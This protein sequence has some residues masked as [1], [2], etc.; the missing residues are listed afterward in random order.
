MGFSYSAYGLCCDFCEQDKSTRK[1]VKKIEC[2]YGYC[3]AWA[4]CD[5]CRTEKKHMACS[6]SAE[7][8]TH[9]KYCL[10]KSIEF[11][12]QKLNEKGIKCKVSALKCSNCKAPVISIEHG[13][14]FAHAC[15][16]EK[17]KYSK[18]FEEIQSLH[19][20]VLEAAA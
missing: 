2:P 3:Q 15:I 18:S 8:T 16:Y 5:V 11:E 4:V 20:K 6:C 12:V 7:K 1:Y 10:P 17:C 9:K 14:K 19:V 13:S